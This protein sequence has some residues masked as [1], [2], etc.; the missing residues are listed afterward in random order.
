ML[1]PFTDKIEELQHTKAGQAQT[2]SLIALLANSNG[3]I[4]QRARYALVEMGEPAVPALIKAL[5]IRND[6]VHWQA[7]KAL[8]QIAS[9]KSIEVLVKMLQD[10]DPGIRWIAAEGLV[11]IGRESLEPLLHTLMHR[12]NS[13][14]LLESAHHVLYD[15]VHHPRLLDWATREMLR[16]IV[17]ALEGSAPV[18]TAPVAAYHALQQLEEDNAHQ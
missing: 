6:Y 18:V 7:A 10:N 13:F 17:E 1:T 12:S 11:A 3:L 14:T 2:D 9:P 15:L 5:N 8:S 16:P 4:R